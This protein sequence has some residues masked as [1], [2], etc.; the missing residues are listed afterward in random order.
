M[1]LASIFKITLT[2]K[3]R[4]FHSVPSLSINHI[5]NFFSETPV[6]VAEE[7]KKQIEVTVIY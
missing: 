5:R 4:N 2:N 3:G 6:Y 7:I 1:L